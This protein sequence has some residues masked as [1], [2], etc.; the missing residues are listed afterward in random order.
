[1]TY[2]QVYGSTPTVVYVGYT[3]GY[4][5]TVVAPGGVV[6]YGTGYYYSPYVTGAYWVPAPYTYGVGAGFGWSAVAGW[7]LA[8]GVGMAVGAYCSPWW[9]PVGYWGW[10]YAAPA[11]GWGGYGGA[12]AA[13]VYGRWGNTAYAGT[14]AAWANPYTGN[15]GS[16]GRGPTTTR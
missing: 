11:W 14:R 12:A 16:G 7:G 9:G 10:G 13:N 15:I 8:F 4:Y 3:P 6:V 1:M 5:G 2:V